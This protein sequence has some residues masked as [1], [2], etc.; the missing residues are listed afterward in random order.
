MNFT[1]HADELSGKS[2]VVF[3]KVYKADENGEPAGDPV[4][5]H[6]DLNDVDQ[7]VTF[8]SI[9]TELID[10]KTGNHRALA[11]KKVKHIDHV[12]YTGLIVGN[13]YTVK[14]VLVDKTSGEK[15][16]DNGKEVAAQLT[17]KAEK[18]D[19]VVDLTFEFD[20]SALEG[21][22]VVA[23]EDLYKEDR[24]IASHSDLSDK[25][26][27]I[28]YPKIATELKDKATDSHT[29]LAAEKMEL[30]DTVTYTNLEAGR[31]YSVKGILMDRETGEALKINNETV[32]AATEFT[33]KDENGTVELTFSINGLSL[34]GKKV[35]AFETL[36]DDSI[37]LAIHADLNDEAQTVIIPGISTEFI[38]NESNSHTAEALNPRNFTDTV[39]YKNLDAGVEYTISGV[40]MDKATGD[41]LLIG[42]KEVTAAKIFRPEETDGNVELAFEFDCTSLAGKE[43][44]AFE[45]L[46]KDKQLIAY[47]ADIY[48]KAQTVGFHKPGETPTPTPK[49]P[50]PTPRSVTP[51]P[52]TPRTP[53]RAS[54]VKTGDTQNVVVPVLM[55]LGAACVLGGIMLTVKKR[56]H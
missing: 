19:G 41:K 20:A 46:Y 17:F 49:T 26:Q 32:T 50:T 27:T 38:N 6:E 3:E 15:I 30:T 21:K 4:A 55:L 34:A 28:E 1:V 11:A 48:D 16:L 22:S 40:L 10:E 9:A 7:T 5:T 56:K 37:E 31:K 25:D 45:Y 36:Y 43:V 18:A 24:L 39:L 12:K 14:G 29:A 53:S 13:E 47:H 51:I 23:F 33:P 8:P 42:G 52:S 35:V 2:V 44:V 54:V